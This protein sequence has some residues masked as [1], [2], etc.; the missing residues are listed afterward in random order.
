MEGAARFAKLVRGA[1][2]VVNGYRP[3]ALERLGFGMKELCRLRPGIIQV[4]VSCYGSDG[5]F[6]DRA[7]W[8]QVAQAVTGICDTQGAAIGAGQP[9]LVFAPVCDYTT[10]YLATYGALLALARRAREGGSWAVHVSLCGS[11]MLLQRQGLLASFA[12][13]PEVS[14][15]DELVSVQVQEDS[16]HGDLMTLGPVLRMSETPPC[17]V[18]PTPSLGA[19]APVWLPR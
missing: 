15:P 13:A 8:E 9:K 17:W 12:D 1:D 3:G 6:A 18:K 5:P 10:G 4:S 19:D 14:R 16:V 11:A 7:G 2:V